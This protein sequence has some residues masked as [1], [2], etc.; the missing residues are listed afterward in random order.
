MALAERERAMSS[1]SG[2][3]YNSDDMLV[4]LGSWT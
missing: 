2:D 1:S 4:V 3:A